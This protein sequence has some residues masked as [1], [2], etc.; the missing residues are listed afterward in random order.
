[1]IKGK[2]LKK[3]ECLWPLLLIDGDLQKYCGCFGFNTGLEKW[4]ASLSIPRERRW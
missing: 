4:D 1:L 2:C 3:T